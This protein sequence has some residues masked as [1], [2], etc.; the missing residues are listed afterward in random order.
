[1]RCKSSAVEKDVHDHHWDKFARLAEHH[2]GVG[3]IRESSESEWC[4]TCDKYRTLEIAP[5]DLSSSVTECFRR[6]INSAIRVYFF[7][8][9]GGDTSI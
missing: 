3:N 8:P 1:V 6:V 5:Q 7:I 2:G 4:G 9:I